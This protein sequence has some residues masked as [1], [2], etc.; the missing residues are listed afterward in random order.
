MN[1]VSAVKIKEVL[2][3]SVNDDQKNDNKETV[4]EIDES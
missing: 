4:V 3:S 1:V 2:D